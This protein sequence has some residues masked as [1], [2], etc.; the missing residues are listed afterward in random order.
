MSLTRP[1]FRY[2]KLQAEERHEL[3]EG[4]RRRLEGVGEILFA[5]V[6]GSFIERN[7]VRDL[8]LAVWIKDPSQAFHYAVDFSAGLEVEMGVPVD[9][10]VLNEAPLP[11][12]YNVFTSGSLLFSKDEALRVRLVDEAVRQYLDLKRLTEIASR[13]VQNPVCKSKND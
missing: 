8:D 10:Q 3:L 2:L 6:H 13:T 11:F 4:L 7:L 12:R 9:I 5:Y 1:E